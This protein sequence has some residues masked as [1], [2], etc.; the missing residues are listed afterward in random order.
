MA[1]TITTGEIKAAVTKK[2][3]VTKVERPLDYLDNLKIPGAAGVQG[4]SGS[5]GATI[6]G[7]TG[8]Q[9]VQGA[10]GGIGGGDILLAGEY[11]IAAVGGILL[12]SQYDNAA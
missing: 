6:Q 7:T 9:G 12:C 1:D 4:T 3:F 11:D 5:Q 10:A 8:A 2:S